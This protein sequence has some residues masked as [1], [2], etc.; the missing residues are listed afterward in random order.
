MEDLYDLTFR[1]IPL[2]TYTMRH[3]SLLPLLYVGYVFA[4]DQAQVPLRAE[5]AVSK[6]RESTLAWSCL[7]THLTRAALTGRF[8]HIT[9]FHPD[10]FY[11]TGST[12]ESGCHEV[13]KK[14]KKKGKHVAN[15]DGVEEEEED[16]VE[17]LKK[18][19]SRDEDEVAGPWGSGV[20]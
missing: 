5:K 4:S 2:S 10:P 13:E 1:S 6:K 11:T 9:D 8:L 15:V 16:D 18:G 12:F 17:A 14:K 20:S 7:E 3:L 19:K